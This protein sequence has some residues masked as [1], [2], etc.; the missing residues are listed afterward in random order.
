M[1]AATLPFDSAM[2]KAAQSGSSRAVMFTLS[3]AASFPS[4][5]NLGR[6]FFCLIPSFAQEA[7]GFEPTPAVRNGSVANGKIQLVCD[8]TQMVT[9]NGVSEP[10]LRA[11][12]TPAKITTRSGSPLGYNLNLC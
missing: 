10:T 1:T 7:S 4:R 2:L 6:A 11:G 12:T 5:R 3:V 9:E 8:E